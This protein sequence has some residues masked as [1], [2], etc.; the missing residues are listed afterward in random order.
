MPF[1]DL[2]AKTLLIGDIAENGTWWAG[3]THIERQELQRPTSKSQEE[4]G[5]DRVDSKTPRI[6]WQELNEWFATICSA[7]ISWRERLARIVDP[8]TDLNYK[9]RQDLF[10]QIDEELAEACVHLQRTVLKASE[11]LLRRPGRPLKKPE[12]CRFLLMILANPFLYPSEYH[13]LS[14]NFKG[15]KRDLV[16]IQAQQTILKPTADIR[17][18]PSVSSRSNHSS[19]CGGLSKHAGII[20]RTL[21]LISTLPTECHQYLVSWFSRLDEPLFHRMVDLVG[22]FVSYRLSRRH[23]RKYSNSHDPTGGLIPNISGPGAGTS[24]HLH[25]ALGP[26]STPKGSESVD[27]RIEYANDWQV[28]AAA[29]TMSL[30]FSANN[31]DWPSLKSD[32]GSKTSGSGSSRL[33]AGSVARKRAHRHGQLVPTNAYYNTMLDYCDLI[34]DFEAWESRRGK[35]SFCQY[36]MFLSIWAKI[37]IMEHDA[38]R[39]MEIKA[40]EAFFSSIMSRKVVNQYLVLKVRR[41]CL[42]EDSLRSVSEVVGTGQEEIKKSLRIDFVG[43]EGLDSGGLRKEWFLLLVREVFDPEHGLFVYDEESHYC[44][45][46]PNTFETSDQ[47]FLVGVLLGLAIY[48]STILDVALPPFAFRRLLASA[49]NH[50][51]PT[52]FSSR[53]ICTYSL[54]DLSEY[55]PSLAQGL[56]QLLSFE[57]DVET[58]FCQD[59]TAVVE[60]YGQRTT[61]PLCHNGDKRPVTN[62][63]RKEFVDL[64]VRYL[65]DA[66]VARQY[67]PFKRGFFTVCAG[68]ALS[69]FRPEEIEL[70]VRGS[71]EPLDVAT[72]RTVAVY[73][74]WSTGC[75]PTKEPVVMWFW[76]AFANANPKDQRKLLGFI[77]ASDRIPAMGAASL[78]IKVVCHGV[79]VGRF[80]TARTCF[81]MIALYRYPTRQVLEEKLWKAVSE[82]EGFGIK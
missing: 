14:V 3:K 33:R 37:R 56:Q 69:L 77:T 29:K 5:S 74:N 22:S 60:R 36:P 13:K 12:D 7:G 81:N 75:D 58:T 72:L 18:G 76:E 4:L 34:S 57:G 44:Y 73:D 39:Q 79:H 8:D 41:D 27:G 24:A 31:N 80:P 19:P 30:L 42:V 2:D 68:N 10:L 50:T 51:G 16:T 15:S 6:N 63:N 55:R 71:D 52:T 26:S 20:K 28:K 49:P 66:S 47:F 43:E 40:R 78:I 25:A 62:A 38:H 11:T 32:T 23:R 17:R 45:F 82:S 21:G 53:P 64:Y 67:E 9:P 70:L 59:F 54:D 48:N 35:F 61:I 46:N 1:P 65:L